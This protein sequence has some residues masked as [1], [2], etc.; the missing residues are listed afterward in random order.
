MIDAPLA[1]RR[2]KSMAGF[3]LIELLVVIAIIAVLIALLL[4]A[5][6]AAREAANRRQATNN[7]NQIALA[8]HAVQDALNTVPTSLGDLAALCR[9][10]RT[11]CQLDEELATGE[12]SGYRY[13]IR[14]SRRGWRLEG[15]PSFA[16]LTGS[17]TV[18]LSQSGEE[19]SMP[20]PG[21]ERARKRA[22]GLLRVQGALA[23]E[24]LFQG[25]PELLPAVQEGLGRSIRDV[26]GHFNLNGDEMVTAEEIFAPGFAGSSV[27]AVQQFLDQARAVLKIGAGHEDSAAHQVALRDLPDGDPRSLYFN[28]GTQ[29]DL[30]EDLVQD[31]GQAEALA[32]KLRLAGRI[33]HPGFRTLLVRSYLFHLGRLVHDDVTR[34]V[35]VDDSCDSAHLGA[36]SSFAA[37]RAARP[38]TR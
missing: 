21:A 15:E 22:F 33:Q 8:V 14:Q 23:I 26:V 6:Q 16:G 4:P 27:P 5:V 34:A 25:N 35:A 20:T 11:L 32:R 1:S 3:T 19:W 13:F 38:G 12:D 37:A 17:D 18:F 7:L 31:R 2:T 30:T 29:A 24:Q 28:F 10:S 9:A 36:L